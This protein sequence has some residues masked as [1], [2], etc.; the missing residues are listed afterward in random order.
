[1]KPFMKITSH[2]GSLK[3]PT[4]LSYHYEYYHWFDMQQYDTMGTVIIAGST[5]KADSLK[6]RALH[7]ILC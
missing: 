6:K 2:T 3:I 4:G 5:S 1:M 7:A